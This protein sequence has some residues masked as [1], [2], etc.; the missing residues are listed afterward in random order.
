MQSIR[1]QEIDNKI[2]AKRMK[3]LADSVQK[4][5][6]KYLELITGIDE[7]QV[8]L[9]GWSKD[10]WRTWVRDASVVLRRISNAEFDLQKAKKI[11]KFLRL[12]S[13]SKNFCTSFVLLEKLIDPLLAWLTPSNIINGIADDILM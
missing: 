11:V 12:A 2:S 6:A 3:V 9:S 7:L 5:D 13:E 4:N 10:L 8:P 1:K